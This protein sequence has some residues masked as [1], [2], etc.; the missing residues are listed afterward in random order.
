M[1]SERPGPGIVRYGTSSLADLLPSALAALGVAH[2][3]S[4]LDLPAGDCIVVL[5]VDGLGWLSLREH[6]ARAPFLSSLAGRPLTA[7]FPTTTA[8]S[9]TSLGTGRPPGEHGIVGYTTRLDGVSEAINWLTWRG[10]QTG[11]D[12]VEA[13]PPE[14]VQPGMTAL[15]RAERAGVNATVVSS[16]QFRESG[17]TRAALRGGLF[18]PSFTAADT[19]TLVADAAR[20][21]GGII[22]C[23][24]ADLDLIGH[25]R[26]CR[27]PAWLAQ[28]ELIDRSTEMLFRRLPAGARLL[29][30]A[31]HGMVDIAESDKIDL[32]DDP[33]LNDGV[34]LIAGEARL[35]YLY[36]QP[37][38]VEAVR[39]RWNRALGDRVALL[40]RDEAIE[41]GWFGPTVL[42]AA[43]G[44]I[45][46]LIAL[47]VSDVAMVR[48]RAES[49]SSMLI[50]NHG[51]LSDAELLVPLLTS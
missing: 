43:R 30:T 17:M 3:P 12:F 33:T 5:L 4:V 13:H 49:R 44:R 2:E 25:I 19:A 50:G 35:R 48:R 6:A 26:G 1:T 31:D 34:T 24:T 11:T 9:I 42:P 14:V 21:R 47:A 28:L 41:L 37:G 7:G 38:Q 32:D 8:A 51:A 20:E 27:S 46:D 15:E 23:Y 29:V 16:P 39:A 40:T 45:G 36:V 18:L 22:Y 10:T